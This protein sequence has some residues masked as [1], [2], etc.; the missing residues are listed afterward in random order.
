MS[1]VYFAHPLDQAHE[2]SLVL[3]D[4]V[5]YELGAAHL[6]SF[7]PGKSWLLGGN[8]DLAG[9]AAIA[10]VN[11]AAQRACD[12]TVAV[13][14]DGV[15]TLGTPAEI[16]RGL[17][18]GKPVVL[19]VGPRT[20]ETV[21]VTE[22]MREGASV[23][24]EPSTVPGHVRSLLSQAEPFAGPERPPALRVMLEGGR[25]PGRGY[26]GDAGFDLYVTQGGSISPGQY[27]E[28]ATDIRLALPPQTWGLLVGRSSTAKR[29]LLV[30]QAVIDNG[31]TGP[32]FFGVTNVGHHTA[33]VS[34]GDRLAQIIPMPL[35]AAGMPVV[36]VTRMP[37]TDRGEAGFGSTG[38]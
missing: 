34:V 9:R 22:W 25:L 10:S 6:T 20:A 8:A 26:E 32:M 5:R 23:T 29:G 18:W 37:V 4:Q 7:Q 12:A 17:Q 30:N 15:P 1:T 14:P 31:Y 36:Q 3:V 16:E 35:L 33:E 11:E 24:Q 13:L 38:S 19:V 2:H 21:Q 28:F 27:I